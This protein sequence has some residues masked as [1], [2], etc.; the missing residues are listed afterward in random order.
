MKQKPME[1]INVRTASQ[2]AFDPEDVDV[3]VRVINGEVLPQNLQI[4]PQWEQ[5][6]EHRINVMKY[7]IKTALISATVLALLGFSVIG[8]IATVTYIAAG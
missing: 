7:W 8:M 2:P 6:V 3:F 4:V 1:I 5:E